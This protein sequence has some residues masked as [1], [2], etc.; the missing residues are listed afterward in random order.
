M[1]KLDFWSWNQTITDIQQPYYIF[2]SIVPEA[3]MFLLRLLKIKLISKCYLQFGSKY[4]Q[5]YLLLIIKISSCCSQAFCG[6]IILCSSSRISNETLFFSLWFCIGLPVK[7]TQLNTSKGYN[8][9]VTSPLWRNHEEANIIW[10]QFSFGKNDRSH[11]NQWKNK[12]LS[13]NVLWLCCGLVVNVN[14]SGCMRCLSAPTGFYR[15]LCKKSERIEC[16][17]AQEAITQ[18]TKEKYKTTLYW[19]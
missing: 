8:N 6:I 14:A 18:H 19:K 5:F 10:W 1:C 9:S 17:Q 15:E 11:A 16:K 12:M 7:C 13:W 3:K 2:F 4:N